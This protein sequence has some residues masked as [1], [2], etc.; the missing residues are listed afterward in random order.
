MILALAG[1]AKALWYLTRGTGVVALLLLTGSIVLGVLTSVRFRTTRWPRFVTAGLHRNLTLLAICFVAVHVLSTLADGY[2]PIG[3]KD[4]VIPFAS[5]Y[6]PVWLG[7]GA[8]AFDLLLALVAT[9]LLRAR[10]GYRLWRR[11]HWL[12]Y[13]SWPIALV[14]ALG[15]GSDAR[16]GWLQIV[17]FGSLAAVALATLGR[18]GLQRGAPLGARVLGAAAVLLAPAAVLAWYHSGPGQPGWAKRAG[19]PA[20]LLASRRR[21]PI[22]V[23]TTLAARLPRVRFTALLGA[24]FREST[25]PSG[26]VHVVIAGRLNGG[27]GGAV[28]IDLRGEALQSG[29]AMTAS[30]VSYVPAGTRTVYLGSVKSLEGSRVVAT[31]RA[32]SGQN[33]KLEFA[34]AIDR[35]RGSAGG[36][37]VVTPGT[38]A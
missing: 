9:S 38:S 26:F 15:T 10:I 21:A 31:A 34:L 33:V 22:S 17:G 25:D 5:P 16:L 27:P 18:L 2:A 37:V 8:V 28:R 36:S 7:L 23:P 32:P 20:S 6:R 4:A 35:S 24:T 1:N 3:L 19:T 14:H 30:G 13:A 12:A 11:V 29:V